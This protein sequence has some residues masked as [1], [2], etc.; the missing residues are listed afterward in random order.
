MSLNRKHTKRS[1]RIMRGVRRDLLEF[2]PPPHSGGRRARKAIRGFK[3]AM[4][5][6]ERLNGQ[7]EVTDQ[8]MDLE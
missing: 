3:R 1:K 5:R 7:D 4:H 2:D 6:M 8:L